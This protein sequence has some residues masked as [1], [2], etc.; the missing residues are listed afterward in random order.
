MSFPRYPKYKDSGVEWL[1]EVPEHWSTA[2]IKRIGR[3]KGG[4]GFPDVYQGVEGEELSFHKVNAIGQ[5][6]RTGFLLPSENTISHSN[7]KVLGAFVFP[8]KSIVF[9]KVGA[10]LLLG[11]IRVLD[12]HACID[13]NMMGLV[14]H[15]EDRDVSFVKYAMTLVRFDLI[16][17]P[18]AVPSLNEGQIGNFRLP[19]PP[20]AE[21]TRVA[22]FLDRETGKI[23]ELVAEQQRLME[24][25]KEKRQAVISHAVTK[26]LNPRAPMKPSGI[27]WLGDVP[28]H[29]AV[30]PVKYLAA[31]GNGSTPNRDKVEYWQDGDYPWLT[32]SAVNQPSITAADEFVSNM[33]LEECHLP[34]IVPPAVLVGITGQGRTRGMASILLVEATINQHLAFLKPLPDRMEV[35]FLRLAFDMLYTYLR[36][37]S[38]EG[39]STKG[40]ITCEQ[41]GKVKL[42]VPPVHEQT[43]IAQFVRAEATKLD[44]LA[45]EAQKAI[46]LLQERRTAL[47]SAAVTGQIDVRKLAAA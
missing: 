18:G 26:G 42:A 22:A 38:E 40:A 12:H 11:R 6:D 5:A 37:D 7:A 36:R 46:D 33:A 21:Q 16:A 32:S 31:I 35:S 39:G 24:L 8:P 27:E 25:L 28:E 2:P 14:V 17:N 20:L 41:I 23:D 47:I 29:W 9:A 19:L 30:Q 4:A 34:K 1:G 15:P 44:N 45:A 13:N 10:A 43:A 3:L